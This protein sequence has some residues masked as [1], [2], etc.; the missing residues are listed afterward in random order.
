MPKADYLRTGELY[1]RRRK[2][3]REQYAEVAKE[4][5]RGAGIGELA[6][7]FGVSKRLI[8][9]ILFPER[10]ERVRERMKKH[11]RDYLKPPEKHAETAREHRAYKIKL[12][13]EEK[14]KF[15]ENKK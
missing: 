15:E 12:F 2:L 14:I 4:Y 10:R 6:R 3:S 13:R 9:F 5:R 7:A 1:D 8:Q 11:W